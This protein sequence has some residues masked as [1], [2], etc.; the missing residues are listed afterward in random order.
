MKRLLFAFVFIVYSVSA[1]AEL[2]A[3]DHLDPTTSEQKWTWTKYYRGEKSKALIVF[4]PGGP[5]QFNFEPV[6]KT[7]TMYHFNNTLKNL[8]YNIPNISSGQFDLVMF[9]SP[10]P[11]EVR[12][13]RAFPQS[14]NPGMRASLDH[15]QRIQSVIEYYKNKTGLPIIVLGHSNG[16]LSISFYYKHF[17]E[18]GYRVQPNL[19]VLSGTRYE[20]RLPVSIKTPVIFIHHKKDGCSGTLFE[21]A[22]LYYNELIRE[23]PK[24]SKLIEIESGVDDG[25]NPCYGNTY[26]M[27]HGSGEEYVSK[28]SQTLLKFLP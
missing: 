27:M 13:G 19:I 26:H 25:G 20:E 23:N 14:Y 22:K 6:K 7:D 28:L 17:L 10:Y 1:R 18:Q 21:D 11:I 2:I 12:G 24:R 9:D 4:I 15:A 3:V 16:G 8:T 5:G